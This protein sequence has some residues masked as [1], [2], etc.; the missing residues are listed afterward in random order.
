[1]KS[2]D[3]RPLLTFLMSGTVAFLALDAVAV[4]QRLDASRSSLEMNMMGFSLD[5]V[6]PGARS[7][8]QYCFLSHIPRREYRGGNTEGG[9]CVS[10]SLA[11]MREKGGSW[12]GTL[13]RQSF[14]DPCG[15]G[16]YLS[17]RGAWVVRKFK[18]ASFFFGTPSLYTRCL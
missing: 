2:G 8:V 13:L 4:R 18:K 17:L 1:M 12:K 11:F 9:E 7:A 5:V 16:G 15:E 3:N 6:K 10:K 14:K